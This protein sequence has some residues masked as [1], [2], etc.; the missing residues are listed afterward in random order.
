MGNGNANKYGNGDGYG[1]GIGWGEVGWVRIGW[2][3]IGSEGKGEAKRRSAGQEGRAATVRTYL[4]LHRVLPCPAVRDIISL[5]D[6]RV[7]SLTFKTLVHPRL[8][9]ISH[10]PSH[11][12]GTLLPERDWRIARGSASTLVS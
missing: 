2:G 10:P 4:L 11:S 8:P 6:K 5:S 9:P 3:A 12:A 1:D 7:L